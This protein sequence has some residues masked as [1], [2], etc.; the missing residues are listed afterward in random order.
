MSPRTFHEMMNRPLNDAERAL[1]GYLANSVP[2]PKADGFVQTRDKG[3]LVFHEF[4][5]GSAIQ[6]HH[7]KGARRFTIKEGGPHAT[8]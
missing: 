8:G 2:F 7:L 5:D 4:K 6:F 1:V 3:I